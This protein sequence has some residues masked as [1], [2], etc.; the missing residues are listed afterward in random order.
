MNSHVHPSPPSSPTVPLALVA[1]LIFG[2]GV[3][4]SAALAGSVTLLVI[5]VVL[6]AAA[7]A[8]TVALRRPRANR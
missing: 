7:L 2:A 6:I 1:V 5:G 8:G 4:G 3:L